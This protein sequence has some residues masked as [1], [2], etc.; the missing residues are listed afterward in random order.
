[1]SE[2]TIQDRVKEY[3]I[4]VAENIQGMPEAGAVAY[5]TV[6]LAGNLPINVTQRANNMYD[7]VAAFKMGLDL[8]TEVFGV[9][10]SKDL[11]Q[12]A[13]PK[14]T[15]VTDEF[16]K[17]FPEPVYEDAE[18]EGLEMMTASSMK[19][20]PLPDDRVKLEFWDGGQYPVI[21]VNK[22]KI[23][24]AQGLLKHVTTQ[25]VSKADEVKVAMKIYWEPGAEFV[26]KGK[27]G[28]YKNVKHIRPA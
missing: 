3:R 5:S 4:K 17:T 16:E 12:A 20:L 9:T 25:D 14:P 22:W 1:M 28:R 26:F 11:P 23:A 18:F 8:I 6:Y 7:A 2:K 21:S 19:I 15:P 13:P 10:L 27:T 24:D